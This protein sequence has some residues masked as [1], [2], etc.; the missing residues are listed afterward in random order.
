MNGQKS[1]VSAISSPPMM[2][3]QVSPASDR[4]LEGGVGEMKRQVTLQTSG[5]ACTLK[6]GVAE[7][8][9]I[10]CART[11]FSFLLLLGFPSFGLIGSHCYGYN[12]YISYIAAKLICQ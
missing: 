5:V 11:M 10:G 8:G 4:S 6:D 3:G 12:V 2:G 1:K 7:K 9:K